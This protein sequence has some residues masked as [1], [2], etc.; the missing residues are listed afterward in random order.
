MAAP[1]CAVYVRLAMTQ[2]TLIIA[3]AAI[4]AIGL[5]WPWL[6]KLGLGRLPGD[7]VIRREGFAFYFPITTMVLA[8]LAATALWRL[9]G[10]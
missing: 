9:F 5:L 8:S 7:I 1:A 2:K 4:L 6:S 10:K 3:G